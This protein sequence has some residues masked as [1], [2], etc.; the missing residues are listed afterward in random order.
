MRSPLDV[1][2]PDDQRRLAA[3]ANQQRLQT[4]AR[5]HFTC[6][7]AFYLRDEEGAPVGIAPGTRLQC[8]ACLGRMP[9]L[10]AFRYAQG[11]KAA[12]GDP[13]VIIPGYG[14]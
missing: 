14:A 3:E 6:E 2:M 5:H 7:D 12:G 10:E 9:A 13:N 8:T 11:Y 1:L 4:C